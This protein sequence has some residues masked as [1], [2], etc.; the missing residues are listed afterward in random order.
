MFLVIPDLRPF[1]EAANGILKKQESKL[2][3]VRG[4]STSK[5]LVPDGDPDDF[6]YLPYPDTK[7]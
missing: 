7:V 1:I 6:E 5:V 3:V 2:P 4:V